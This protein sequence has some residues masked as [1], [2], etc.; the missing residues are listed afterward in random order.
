MYNRDQKESG[1]AFFDIDASKADFFV[2]QPHQVR[3]ALINCKI[4]ADTSQIS[5]AQKDEMDRK[6]YVSNLPHNTSDLDLLKIFLPHARLSKAYLVRN[7]SDGSC[8]NFGFV[9]FQSSRDLDAFLSTPQFLIYRGR[10]LTIKKAVDRL[11]QKNKRLNDQHSANHYN[12]ALRAHEVGIN[13]LIG[14]K[15]AQI[16]RKSK[17]LNESED[18]Y[19]F[20]R[21]ISLPRPPRGPLEA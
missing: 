18:N 8:K 19:R 6:L 9:V 10:K 4:A 7:R 20:I 3:N 17:F 1:Y 12:V 16:L 21:Q 13:Y 11:T 5:E 15:M 2:S 14:S